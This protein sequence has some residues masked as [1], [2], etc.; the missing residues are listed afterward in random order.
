M[1]VVNFP[2]LFL[3]LSEPFHISHLCSPPVGACS[4]N[5]SCDLQNK[6]KNPKVQL[7]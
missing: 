2:Q 4:Q 1:T 6:G 5:G 7:L 3:L